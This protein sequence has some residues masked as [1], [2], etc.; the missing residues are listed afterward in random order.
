LSWRESSDA[1]KAGKVLQ[2]KLLACTYLTVLIVSAVQVNDSL[3]ETQLCLRFSPLEVAAGCLHLA[4]TTLGVAERLP[5][6]KQLGWWGAIGV[7][8]R[9]IEEVAH[10][11]C[12]AAEARE[13]LKGAASTPLT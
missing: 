9:A 2:F 5:R 10:C 6:S 1:E 7:E 12:D 4:S 11:L 3:G 8:Q 13:Q